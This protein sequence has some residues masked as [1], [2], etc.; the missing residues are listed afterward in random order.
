MGA[1]PEGADRGMHTVLLDSVPTDTDV[2]YVLTRRPRLPEIVVTKPFLFL[3]SIDG[4]IFVRGSQQQP[5][6]E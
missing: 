2:F 6:I 4:S 3:V 5:V 1:P